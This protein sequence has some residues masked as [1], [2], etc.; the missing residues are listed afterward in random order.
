MRQNGPHFPLLFTETLLSEN[1]RNHIDIS[2][3]S[4]EGDYESY[5]KAT[6]MQGIDFDGF[7]NENY[8]KDNDVHC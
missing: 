3:T 7:F 1:N 6:E 8:N 5:V 2:E 4:F